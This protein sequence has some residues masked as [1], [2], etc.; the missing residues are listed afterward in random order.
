M[1]I[2]YGA[3]SIPLLPHGQVRLP[4]LIESTVLF[5]ATTNRKKKSTVKNP[6]VSSTMT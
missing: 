2:W 3:V 5:R 6:V 1:R 4:E